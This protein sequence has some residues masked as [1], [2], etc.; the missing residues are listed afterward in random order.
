MVSKKDLLQIDKLRR[1]LI[2][3][4][5]RKK[6]LSEKPTKVVMDSVKSSS[7]EFPYT[8]HSTVI[9]GIEDRKNL[10]KYKRLIYE[11]EEKLQKQI[12]EI[13]YELN[14]I[15]DSEIRQI[16]RMRYEDG[17]PWS[18]IAIILKYENEEVPRKRLNR[19]LDKKFSRK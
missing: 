15:D 12:N 1:E 8:R 14:N 4:Q 18:K 11:K 10:R 19:Y 9:E 5:K 6:R 2:D 16:I 13:E 7:R 17:F 3:L